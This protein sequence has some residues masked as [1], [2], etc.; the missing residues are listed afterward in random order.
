MKKIAIV[1]VLP[2]L[3]VAFLL[4]SCAEEPKYP[5]ATN[6]DA[7]L[8]MEDVLLV[9]GTSMFLLFEAEEA[10]QGEMTNDSESVR[11]AWENGSGENSSAT[12]TISL[13][14][15]TIGSDS[16]FASDYNGYEMSGTIVLS[17]EGTGT[18]KMDADLHMSHETPDDF[19]VRRLV[20]ELSGSQEEDGR[21]V[22]SGSLTIN[23]R[24]V[25]LA[26]MS[27]AFE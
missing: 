7:V 1:N 24:E 3:L 19:P 18:N 10:A 5:E 13:A 21:V 12:Y 6:E 8:A 2:F 27:A 4:S 14:E 9:S 23:G 11:L 20:M 26:L 16:V 22:P 17:S 25:D 15:H